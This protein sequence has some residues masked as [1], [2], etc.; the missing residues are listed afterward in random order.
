MLTYIATRAIIL[1][2]HVE[3]I[4]KGVTYPCSQCEF[5]ATTANYL[6]RHVK[7]KHKMLRYP[8]PEC[9]YIAS[10]TIVL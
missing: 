2:V 8:C 3:S 9:E 5:D 7:S 4:H 10:R 6:R 1:K